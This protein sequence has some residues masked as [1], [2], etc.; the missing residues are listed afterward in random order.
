LSIF[1]EHNLPGE[2]SDIHRRLR[3]KPTAEGPVFRVL[4]EVTREESLRPVR[5]GVV[6]FNLRARRIVQIQNTYD[7]LTQDGTVNYHNGKFLSIRSL[8]Y[9]LPPSWSIVP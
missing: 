6:L 5:A 7:E 8:P 4:D 9:Q 2:L 3:E 1:D